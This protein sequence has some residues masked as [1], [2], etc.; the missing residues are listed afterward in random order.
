MESRVTPKTIKQSIESLSWNTSNAKISKCFTV[1]E[2][3]WA[4]GQLNW[5]YQYPELLHFPQAGQHLF[6]FFAPPQ[7]ITNKNTRAV[8]LHI[9]AQPEKVHYALVF[10]GAQSRTLNHERKNSVGSS[11]GIVI[12]ASTV[13]IHKG[14][15]RSDNAGLSCCGADGIVKRRG[16]KRGLLRKQRK[17][18]H[19]QWW[20]SESPIHLFSRWAL[21]VP[22]R[23]RRS[24]L[25]WRFHAAMHAHFRGNLKCKWKLFQNVIF[26]PAFVLT[27]YLCRYLG[28]PKALM[29]RN[30]LLLI[31]LCHCYT[32]LLGRVPG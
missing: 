26:H 23:S 13:I 19:K 12:N 18:T 6:Y 29:Y 21:V 17:Q 7:T 14:L 30:L 1:C 5:P 4:V 28:F 24:Q 8:S 25:N 3:Q 2:S 10:L 16:K 15:A 22:V 9:I 20:P 31:N 27:S 32:T 11:N